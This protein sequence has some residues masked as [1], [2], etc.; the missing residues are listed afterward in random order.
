MGF[1]AG[2]LVFEGEDRAVPRRRVLKAGA[3]L[4][5][6]NATRSALQHQSFGGRALIALSSST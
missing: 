5:A 2:R 3:K 4:R 6:D 1:V